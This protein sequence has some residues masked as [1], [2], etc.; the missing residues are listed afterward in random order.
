MYKME[1]LPQTPIS[2]YFFHPGSTKCI[3]LEDL[4]VNPTAPYNQPL[5]HFFKCQSLMITF[6]SLSLSSRHSDHL[7]LLTPRV[8]A[9]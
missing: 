1:R 7:V 3:P 5:V 4:V 2:E 8:I 6:Y 9:T